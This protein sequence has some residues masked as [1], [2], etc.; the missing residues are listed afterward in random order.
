MANVRLLLISF[1]GLQIVTEKD[2]FVACHQVVEVKVGLHC[3]DCIKKILKAIKKM[4]GS[5]FSQHQYNKHLFVLF[6]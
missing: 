3:D 4:E 5:C 6:L 1:S 2:F